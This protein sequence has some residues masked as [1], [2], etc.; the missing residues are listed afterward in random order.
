MSDRYSELFLMKLM[1]INYVIRCQYMTAVQ[2]HLFTE[3]MWKG[4]CCIFK[5]RYS[6]LILNKVKTTFFSKNKC[7]L[8][9]LDNL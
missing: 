5:I 1:G 2:I 8:F 6:A 9:V 7:F 4:T 3:P